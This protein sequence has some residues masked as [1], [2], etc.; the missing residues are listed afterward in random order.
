MKVLMIT[1]CLF[2]FIACGGKRIPASIAHDS[3]KV[4]DGTIL[5]T[6]YFSTGSAA[7]DDRGRAFLLEH[8]TWLL[9]HDRVGL[10]LEGHCDER[11]SAEMNVELGDRRARAVRAFLH[12]HGVS[13]ARPIALLSYGESR[14]V[15][16]RH[17]EQS[18]RKNRRVEFIIR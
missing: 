18:W 9:L 13:P 16:R 1:M 11:G 14:P 17:N 15:D 3:Q 12:E 2:S 6:I 8:A 7:L 4:I 10:I 5:Q